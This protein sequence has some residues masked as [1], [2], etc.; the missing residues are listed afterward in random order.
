MKK[1]KKKQQQNKHQQRFCVR[2]AVCACAAQEEGGRETTYTPTCSAFQKGLF[3]H[4]ARVIMDASL[5]PPGI[6]WLFLS[7]CF[8]VKTIT[9]PPP[10]HTHIK[11]QASKHIA[12][13]QEPSAFS[14][15]VS[16]KMCCCIRFPSSF[17]PRR[18]RRRHAQSSA[19]IHQNQLSCF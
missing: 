19:E 13:P 15:H 2:A 3:N 8:T 4:K 10:T 16:Q 9:P 7:A 6:V 1:I 11:T 14:S 12:T 18:S 5:Q 17:C